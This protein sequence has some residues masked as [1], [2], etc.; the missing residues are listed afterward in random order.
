MSQANTNLL[1]VEALTQGKVLADSC[2]ALWF[3][4]LERAFEDARS[5]SESEQRFRQDA[6]R[7]ITSD[8]DGFL[9]VCKALDLSP[10]Y[11]RSG[12]V[13]KA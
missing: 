4:T 8:R 5:T 13:A 11:L 2:R 1:A 9:H 3:A 7:W 10:E 12:L 6:I